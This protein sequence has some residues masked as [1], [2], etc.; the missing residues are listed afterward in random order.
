M[1]LEWANELPEL[2]YRYLQSYTTVRREFGFINIFVCGLSTCKVDASSTLRQSTQRCV[3]MELAFIRI[4]VKQEWEQMP[5]AISNSPYSRAWR[6]LIWII[7]YAVVF[8]MC[9][10]HRSTN[11][12]MDMS[13]FG[14]IEIEFRLVCWKAKLS[15]TKLFFFILNFVSFPLFKF[16]YWFL[17]AL[18]SWIW[19]A[20]KSENILID[21]CGRPT[22]K[23][24]FRCVHWLPIPSIT[25]V[26][27]ML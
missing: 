23:S 5:I 12:D 13:N 16:N 9:F 1:S 6:T 2:W 18:P 10:R 14:L 11:V 7:Y 24:K 25:K 27:R 15:P 17:D 4:K 26:W 22:D 19:I 8:W 20:L 3:E 21:S